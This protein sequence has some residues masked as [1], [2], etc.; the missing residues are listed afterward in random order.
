[1]YLE[2]RAVGRPIIIIMVIGKK[3]TC[4]DGKPMWW[5]RGNV[6]YRHTSFT[7][8]LILWFEMK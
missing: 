2:S 1:M 7:Q 6:I 3:V 8:D 5:R 4:Y